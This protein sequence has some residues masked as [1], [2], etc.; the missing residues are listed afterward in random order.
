M[1]T[2]TI[3]NSDGVESTH[4]LEGARISIGRSEDSDLTIDDASLSGNHAE[5]VAADGDYELTDLGS[6]NGTYIDGTRIE[7][8]TLKDRD[9]LLFGGIVATFH[10]TSPD[11]DESKEAPTLSETL[12]AGPA[13]TSLRPNSFSNASPFTKKVKEKDST[14]QAL[15]FIGALGIA[16]AVAAI[17]CAFMM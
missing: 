7:S 12:A 13:T 16:A 5:I 15:I 9:H 17:V 10:S 4:E 2:L 11:P 8:V 14:G 1:A 3:T 6:T